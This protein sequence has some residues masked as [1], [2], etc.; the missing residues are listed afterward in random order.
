MRTD[1]IFVDC[2]YYAFFMSRTNLLRFSM[3][4]QSKKRAIS[5]QPMQMQRE[6]C[7]ERSTEKVYLTRSRSR[8]HSLDSVGEESPTTAQCENKDANTAH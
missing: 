3:Q 7:V 8:M 6:I 4:S 5:L 1:L 2:F